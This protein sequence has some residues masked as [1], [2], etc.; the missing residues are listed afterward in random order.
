MSN[1]KGFQSRFGLEAFIDS[2]RRAELNRNERFFEYMLEQE[3]I[4]Q[5]V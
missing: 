4:P 3:G 5:Q 2:T 1:N